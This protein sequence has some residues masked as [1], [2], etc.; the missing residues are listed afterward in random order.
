M[1]Y[2][3]DPVRS[4]N[5]VPM[6]TGS[7]SAPTVTY[8]QQVGTLDFI[9]RLCV[10][11]ITMNLATLSGGAGSAFI[12]LPFKPARESPYR[13]Y[14]ECRWGGFT[15]PAGFTQVQAFITGGT[16]KLWLGRSGSGVA[17]TTVDISE[18][19][20]TATIGLSLMVLV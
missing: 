17:T 4:Y 20:G 15:L 11:S 2:D 14:G 7:T 10:V 13:Y 16:Q 8:S 9:G 12:L 18:L 19:G 5:F 6:L 1:P 3:N